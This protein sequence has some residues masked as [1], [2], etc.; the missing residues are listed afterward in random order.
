MALKHF[1]R[2]ADPREVSTFIAVH[3]YA[4]IDDLADAALMDRLAREVE[5]YVAA[6]D[7][8]RDEYDG[9]QTGS[10]MLK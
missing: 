9:Q 8:G 5:P 7:A 1:D 4:I 10:G 6:S 2:D 3:G